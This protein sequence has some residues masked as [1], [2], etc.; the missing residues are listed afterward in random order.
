MT[1]TEKLAAIELIKQLK[2][3]YLRFIDTKDYEGL[4]TVFTKDAVMDLRRAMEKA[5]WAKTVT[6][7]AKEAASDSGG[8]LFKGPAA[9]VKFVRGSTHGAVTVHRGLMPEIDVMSATTA[10]GIWAQ[11]DFIQWSDGP[12]LRSLHGFGHYHE[13]YKRVAGLWLIKSTVMTRLRVDIA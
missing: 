7:K 3:R 10:R 11:E 5:R 4:A 13:T 9:I 6:T 8:W 1:N 2:A 12:R